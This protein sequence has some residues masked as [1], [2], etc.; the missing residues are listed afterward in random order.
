MGKSYSVAV[1][2]FIDATLRD[3]AILTDAIKSILVR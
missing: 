1:A 3:N 2:A